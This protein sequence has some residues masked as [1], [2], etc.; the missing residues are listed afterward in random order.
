MIGL[1]LAFLLVLGLGRLGHAYIDWLW[2][3]SLGDTSVFWTTLAGNWGIAL[4]G[5][6]LAAVLT[7]LNLW[8]ARSALTTVRPLVV[9]V[10]EETPVWRP[11]PLR[12]FAIAALLAGWLGATAAGTQ[13]LVVLR[14]WNAVPFGG[15]VDPLFGKDMGFYI[16][17]LPLFEL[18]YQFVMA[19]LVVNFLAAAAVYTLGG[20]AS[21]APGRLQVHPRAI[22]HLSALVAGFFG[23]KAWG[24]ALNAYQLVYSPRGV[25]FGA[26]YADVHANLP[27]LR[28]LLVLAIAA[29]VL[30]LVSVFRRV[31]VQLV[32]GM[33]L[34]AI[35]SVLLG[36]AWP[37]VVQNFVVKPSE[38]QKETPYIR[39][40][41]AST[42]RA[43]DLNS[44]KTQVYPAH[45]EL[46]AADVTADNPTIA[47]TRLWD[48]RVLG[49]TYQQLQGLRSY[50]QFDEMD[51]DRYNI[52]G[53]M[54]QV[55]IA[56]REI[57][58][59]K[60]PQQTWINQHIK[61]THGYGV[62]VSP[63]AR[64]GPDGFPEFWVKDVPPMASVP[65]LKVDRP[66]IYYGE[67]TGPYAI[68]NTREEEFDY[69]KGETNAYARYSGKGGI[70]V[71]LAL[72]RLAFAVDNQDYNVLFT[73]AIT[74]ESR[75][76]IY[77]N[78]KD[79][80]QR[81]APYLLYD[82]DPYI[83]IDQGRLVWIQDAY[84]ASGRFPFAEPVNPGGINYLRNSVKVTIDAYNGD[85]HFYIAD[86]NDPILKAYAAIYPGLFRPLSELPE[87]LVPH[88]RFP[89][90]LF[91]VKGQMYA[92]YH[93]TD[94]QVFYNSEDLWQVA[95]E[96]GTQRNVTAPYYAILQLAGMD[97][98]EYL[99]LQTFT[100]F[101]RTNMVAWLGA[102]A[103]PEHTGE[104]IAYLFPK[105]KTVLGPQQ[106]ES[107][108][109]STPAISQ[110]INLWN[111]Q[112][113]QVSRGPLFVIPLKDSLLYIQSLFL[114][115][116]ASPLPRMQRVIVAYGDQVNMA[117]T[118]EEALAGIFG[119]GA[120]PGGATPG[121]GTGTTPGTTPGTA[122]GTAP[123]TTPG[124][125]PGTAPGPVASTVPALTA[126]ANQLYQE[127]QT[128]LR[129]GDF[130]GYG[131]AI[132]ELGEVLQRLQQL[133]GPAA[134]TP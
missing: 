120:P 45:H 4:A 113:S 104:M 6:L 109:N 130:A 91:Q 19:L 64:V 121:T 58:Y 85:V 129:S 105:E 132:G 32:S 89:E 100:P 30:A 25:A 69:P 114:Q 86:P 70:P 22:S 52:G 2:F 55:M 57:N 49:Q 11:K 27:A 71:G 128:A 5:G 127:A 125:T 28:V 106:V 84:T 18:I 92:K 88:L 102:R 61:Y 20:L 93:M 74:G 43:Y 3:T 67:Q 90:Y 42:R 80:V 73:G 33:V 47:N 112:G 107:N 37:T 103:D 124:T 31:L 24:Y 9:L 54:R 101:K 23:L 110:S 34:M 63:A 97:R 115:G 38:I 133:A 116:S 1:G 99:L 77:R 29:A 14:A 26:S 16:F 95:A 81:I 15:E 123:G 78:I 111:Q 83:V 76:L 48:W 134:T 122:P 68:V 35:A 56:A 21:Y 17:Q 7:F 8:P 65:E 117:A 118:L 98:P 96:G 12:I 119:G 13:W 60:L 87:S 126:R 82:P 51:V 10:S 44:I 79:R 41:I 66:E 40:N 131:R 62:T 46:T 36:V 94:P 39:Y 75:A 59:T 53:Q 50:Y 108:V 72:P